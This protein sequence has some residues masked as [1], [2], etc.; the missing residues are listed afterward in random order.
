MIEYGI[1]C[2][3]KDYFWAMR[4]RLITDRLLLAIAHPINPN[5]TAQLVNKYNE[6]CRQYANDRCDYTEGE[7]RDMYCGP[8]FI[9]PECFSVEV[10]YI[11]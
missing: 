11:Q 1:P 9:R 5:N 4:G 10:M 2:S 8:F 6:Y 3:E 7:L